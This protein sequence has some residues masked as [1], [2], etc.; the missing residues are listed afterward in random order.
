MNLPGRR[1]QAV[2][3]LCYVFLVLFELDEGDTLSAVVWTVLAALYFI[4]VWRVRNDS[5]GSDDSLV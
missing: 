4:N 2:L 3:F 1:V 5:Q